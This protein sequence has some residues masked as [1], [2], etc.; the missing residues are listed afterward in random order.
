MP[1]NIFVCAAVSVLLA[2]L[3]KARE[4]TGTTAEGGEKMT[5]KVTSSAFD[6]QGLIPA[7]YTCQ[8]QNISPPL[9]FQ[10]EIEGTKSIAL[11]CD[12]PDAPI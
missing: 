12:D 4:N 2:C 7:K 5:I 1:K 3:C 10:M 11:I 6:D 9:Q 8:G